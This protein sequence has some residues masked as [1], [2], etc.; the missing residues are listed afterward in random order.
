MT[1]YL[2]LGIALVFLSS[3]AGNALL[4]K[5]RTHLLKEIGVE[6]GKTVAV[7]GERDQAIAAGAQCSAG[8]EARAREQAARD[9]RVK[10]DLAMALK[11]MQTLERERI[12]LLQ[13]PP[14]VIAAPNAPPEV[15]REA[16]CES[17]DQ[18]NQELLAQRRQRKP[19]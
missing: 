16:A 15:I 19:S 14:T 10:A 11:R 7:A 1:V 13:R 8:V 17:A 4:W 6:Q 5:N 3:L 2:Y 18:L 9:K 12:A